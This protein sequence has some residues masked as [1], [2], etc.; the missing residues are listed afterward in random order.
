ME[1]GAGEK[2]R[3]GEL[4]AET[5]PFDGSCPSTVVERSRN[6]AQ[7]P[8]SRNSLRDW[9]RGAEKMGAGEVIGW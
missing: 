3:G 5:Q 9:R 1:R 8:R 4:N 2:R 6:F 7:E